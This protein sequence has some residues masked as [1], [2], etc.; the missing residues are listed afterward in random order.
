MPRP[1]HAG[2]GGGDSGGKPDK[3]TGKN[4]KVAEEQNAI[5][6]TDGEDSLVG[7]EGDD[8]I[9]GLGGDDTLNGW[10][11]HNEMDG[12]EGSDLYL[13][14][15][16]GS[17]MNVNDT[18]SEGYDVI[19]AGTSS[20]V[21]GFTEFSPDSG[22]EE[23]SA[24][25]YAAVEVQGTGSANLL[26]FSETTVTGLDKIHGMGG[27]DTIV[28]SDGD[29]WIVGGSGD[30]MLTGGDGSDSLNGGMGADNFTLAAGDTGLDTIQDLDV[31]GGDT[32]SLTGFTSEGTVTAWEAVDETPDDGIDDPILRVL[33]ENGQSEDAA[34]LMGVSEDDLSDPDFMDSIL[35]L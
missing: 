35:F 21:I 33:Y 6:G 25:G 31:A 19:S 5:Y 2:G 8:W 24:G 4:G 16:R 23:V 11:G 14:Y 27:N 29:D 10:T 20:S 32:I 13:V 28:G 1:D 7:T 26:D 15:G 3:A 17:T 9:Y 34:I 30:D 12:G 18:G 22:V